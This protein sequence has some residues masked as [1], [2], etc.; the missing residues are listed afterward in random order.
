MGMKE[1]IIPVDESALERDEL[2]WFKEQGAQKLVRCKDCK[3]NSGKCIGIYIQ[4]ITC[5]KTGEIHKEDWFCADG[6]ER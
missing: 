5:G 3:C 4:F 2:E 6:K 1:Y